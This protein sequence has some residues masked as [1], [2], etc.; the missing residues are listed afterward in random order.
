MK[1]FFDIDNSYTISLTEPEASRLISYCREH[2]VTTLDLLHKIIT[3]GFL[4]VGIVID[5][6]KA[7]K[8]NG[9][10]HKKTHKKSR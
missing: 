10:K 4:L 8:V 7:V 1:M 2:Q 3:C 6:E 5:K 9:K